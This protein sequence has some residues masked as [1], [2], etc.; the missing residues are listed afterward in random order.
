M[1]QGSSEISVWI[2]FFKEASIPPKY[3]QNYATKFIENR[4]R[5]E[6]LGDLD[7]PL[8]NELGITAIGDCLSILKHAKTLSLKLSEKHL[9]SDTSDLHTKS[10][11]KNEVAKRIIESCLTRSPSNSDSDSSEKGPSLKPTRKEKSN[12]SSIPADVFSRL[13]FNPKAAQVTS[14]TN[15]DEAMDTSAMRKRKLSD[16]DDQVHVLEYKGF[17]KSPEKTV[18]H[19]KNNKRVL[20]LNE[21]IKLGGTS[22]TRHISMSPVKNTKNDPQNI[23]NRLNIGNTNFSRTIQGL[24]SPASAST[25]ADKPKLATVKK[26][27]SLKS[28]FMTSSVFKRIQT[29]EAVE[30]KEPARVENSFKNRISGLNT[31]NAT[32]TAPHKDLESNKNLF[33]ITLNKNE[34]NRTIVPITYGSNV[35][36]TSPVTKRQLSSVVRTVN[37]STSHTSTNNNN[38]REVRSRIGR[39]VYSRIS[40]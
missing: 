28:D 23:K 2:K 19:L 29:P 38:R 39:S 32:K 1:Q 27:G 10:N 40:M 34:S 33:K 22:L 3:A 12:S 21:N 6:M 20:S 31:K 4:I 37:Q 5:F 16:E 11:K 36:K 14:T 30:P 9:E 26:F 13:N 15:D 7:R 18:V 24:R 17:M 25:N 8:L 35:Q